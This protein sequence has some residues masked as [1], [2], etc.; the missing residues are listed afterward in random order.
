MSK[1]TK[2]SKN[3]H[4][5][6]F[7]LNGCENLLKSNKYS[8]I[9]VDLM[10]GGNASRKGELK[11]ILHKV[12]NKVKM[13]P[14]DTFLKK[15]DQFRTQ[16]I[17]VYFQGAI[18]QKP[19]SYNNTDGNIGLLILDNIEDPQNAGQILRT[20][21][22]S[23]IDGVVFPGHHSVGATPTVLQVSQG[24]FVH[25]NLY[26]CGNLK[27]YIEKLKQQGFW[28]VALENGIDAKPWYEIDLKGKIAI[29]VGSE[30]KGIRQNILKACDFKATIPMQ[31]KVNSL[32]VSAAVS[33]MVL[34]RERQILSANS[35]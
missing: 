1:Q 34:E 28:I 19:K 21:E 29:I 27:Q 11:H 26:Q 7:G 8:I 20:A 5:F 31:G 6:I 18:L 2:F 23:G 33:A 24:A 35:E 17:V 15:Y 3:K 13:L 30:G 22:C 12:S 9:S 14:R 16:G 10:E 4:Q 25:L 32:N